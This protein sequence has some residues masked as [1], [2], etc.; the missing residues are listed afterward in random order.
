MTIRE[1][2]QQQ[3]S[4]SSDAI[5]QIKQQLRGNLLMPEDP[6][7]D[8]ARALWN[9]MIDKRPALII[10]PSGVADIITAVSSAKHHDLTLAIKGGGHNVAG[11]AVFDGGLLLDMSTMRSV[12]VDPGLKTAYVQG[13]ALWADFDH[14]TAAHNLTATGGVVSTTGVAGLTLGGGI[15]WLNPK[16]GASCDNV[17]AY[18]VVLA[19]GSFVRVTAEEHPDLF[20]ALKGGGGNFGV[21]TGFLFQLH[22][23]GHQVL[24]GGRFYPMSESRD[25]LGF[26]RDFTRNSSRDVVVY[27]AIFMN[28]ASGENACAIAFCHS[29]DAESAEQEMAPVRQYGEADLDI[30]SPMPYTAWQQAFD[31]LLPHGRNYYWKA[32]LFA[33]LTDEILDITDEHG[34]KKPN[35]ISYAII[36]QFGGAY[37]DVGK[38]D[39]A[40]WARD[41]RH[42]LVIGGAWDDPADQEACIQWVRTF[43]DALAPHA[44]TNRNLN[45]TVVEEQEKTDRVRA[46]YGE[47]YERLAQIKS[48]Y[49]PTNFF[50]ANNNISPAE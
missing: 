45:F 50:H 17:L 19:D 23:F 14:E 20:W 12:T 1:T 49:D 9:G 29:G 11:N 16:F 46:S 42:Q 39:T 6:G 18:D 25:L 31:P 36:E 33:E 48:W 27:S 7:Y 30:I 2:P 37:G 43:H 4:I 26:Y 38:T 21:V 10:Q 22:P 5:E 15:G 35:E 44:A 8:D 13:G 28:P 24:A 32:L 41:I 40:F 3:P 47:N 34:S